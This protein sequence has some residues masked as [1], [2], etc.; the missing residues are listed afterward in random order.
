MADLVEVWKSSLPAVLNN[1]TGR[2][3][4][5]ALNAAVPILVDE[6]VLI[7]GI[8]ANDTEL[9][10]HLRLPNTSRQIEVAF[11][12]KY[13]TPVK[14]RVIGGTTPEDYEIVK[15]RDAERRR[16]QEAEM[17]K[18]RAELQSKST[19]EGV[20]E[21]LSRRFSAIT[22]RSLP[23]N[24]AR[25]YA[26]ALELVAEARREHQESDDMSERNFARCLERISQYSDVPSTLVAE[27]VLKRAGEL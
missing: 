26:E 16:M 21:Q 13:G 4:W 11:S 20:Y 5:T 17:T 10:G 18:L 6:G 23:Q 19:W 9:A 22:N 27:E 7:L 3:V 8:P 15:R 25:F 2:G 14:V 12:Q 1:V 24:K